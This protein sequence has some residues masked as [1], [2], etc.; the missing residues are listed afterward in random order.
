M[1]KISKN[2]KNIVN[3]FKN[4]EKNFSHSRASDTVHFRK[5]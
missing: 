3:K 2:E 5:N 4:N 1:R